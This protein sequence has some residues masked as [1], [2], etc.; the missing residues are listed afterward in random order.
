MLT[1]FHRISFAINVFP[2]TSVTL[3]LFNPFLLF[4]TPP[5]Q[6]SISTFITVFIPAGVSVHRRC[7]PSHQMITFNLRDEE[8]ACVSWAP[9][10]G[11]AR[12]LPHFPPR[13]VRARINHRLA[14]RQRAR[15][16]AAPA[17]RR[18]AAAL[19]A[20]GSACWGWCERWQGVHVP[21]LLSAPLGSISGGA[22][23]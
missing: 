10:R 23:T 14:G 7:N 13:C 22:G 3:F 12:H 19:G 5:R 21:L 16:C 11:G 9:V 20:R 18:P 1:H 8:T 2:P 15:F 6:F 17:A 4:R